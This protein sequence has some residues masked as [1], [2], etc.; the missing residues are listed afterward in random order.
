MAP[1]ASK[2][3]N[4]DPPNILK[5]SSI[6]NNNKFE[7]NDNTKSFI[8]TQLKKHGRSTSPPLLSQNKMSK[9]NEDSDE[10]EMEF[11]SNNT[12]SST[13]A[14]KPKEKNQKENQK[15]ME[16]VKSKPIVV[17]LKQ[18]NAVQFRE[19]VQ[20]LGLSGE[21]YF[22]FLKNNQIQIFTTTEDDKKKIIEFLSKEKSHVEFHTFTETKDKDKIYVLKNHHYIEPSELL[23]I[24]KNETI[25]ATKVS[26]LN[27]SK[28]NPTYLVH[29][30]KNVVNL[31][32][33]N[34]QFKIIDHSIIKWEKFM[35]NNKKMSQCYNCQRVGH[36]ARNC[37]HPYRCVKCLESHLPGQCKRKS[38]EEG[39]PHCVNCQGEHA[40]NSKNCKYIKD[41]LV[42]IEK[43][44]KPKIQQ[45]KPRSF[46]STP[47]PW[48][49]LT[50]FPPLTQRNSSVNNRLLEIR[51]SEIVNNLNEDQGGSSTSNFQQF[52]D[53]QSEFSAIPN[54][55]ETL[56]LYKELISKLKSTNCQ[57]TRVG[58]LIEYTLP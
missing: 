55:S 52:S 3:K 8:K 27:N 22:K 18:L 11:D 28:E 45:P 1:K 4:K 14:K 13:S 54:I 56:N 38:P 32:I 33:L 50:Q 36:T 16:K 40:A 44:R 39:V 9:I 25:P 57:K 7:I 31:N 12:S 46:T 53:L 24:L 26:L 21:Y 43:L 5:T 19:K 30:E 29:F 49:N 20:Q 41:Y 17:D 48:A 2:S 58:I 15:S 37:G 42:K 35:P 34:S 23:S 51:E 10:E 6:V 47:A